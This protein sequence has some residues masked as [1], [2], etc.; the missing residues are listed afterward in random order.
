MQRTP[1]ASLLG[2]LPGHTQDRGDIRP[3]PTCVTRAAYEMVHEG[4]GIGL[5]G[6]TQTLRFSEACQLVAINATADVR[7]QPL[8]LGRISHSSMLR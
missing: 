2:F 8:D 6:M 5:H 1:K 3:R 7:H 4:L